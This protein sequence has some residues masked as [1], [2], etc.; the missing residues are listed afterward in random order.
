MAA[1]SAAEVKRLREM[2]G[3]GMMDCKR[4]LEEAEGDF[5]KAVELLRIKGAK[6]VG[7]RDSRTASNGLVVAHMEGNDHGVLLEL[8]CETDFVAKTEG[9][10]GLA[11]DV[12]SFVASKRPGD[13]AEL[14]A[15]EL[16][17][18]K[19]IQQLLDEANVTLGEK[20]E[21]R[22]FVRFED[23][24]IYVYLHKHDPA[25][26]PSVGSLVELDTPNEELAKG[27]AQHIAAMAPKYLAR[28]DVPQD[29]VDNERRIA[30]E[31][32]REEGKPEQAISKIVDG[33]T[34]GFF[35]DAC[36]LEQSYVRDNKKTIAALL[37]ENGAHVTRFARFKVGQ[38]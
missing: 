11:A 36:L 34:N 10:Q 19:T 14:M 17:A 33:R 21:V 20:I 30:E 6:D 31:T 32:A 7:K 24:S 22:R 25:L 28:E 23:G 26:P 1:V 4:A 18:D 15:A 38:D 3:A 35:K 37:A 8:N 16:E 2:T 5:D 29:V 9:F 12:S 13:V 27:I